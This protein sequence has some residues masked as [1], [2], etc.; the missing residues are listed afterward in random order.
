MVVLDIDPERVDMVN[1]RQSTVSDT[2]IETFLAQ[3]ELHL[4]ATLDK[5][6]AYKKANFVV[7][8]TPTNY[9]PQSNRFDTS[10]VDN[11]VNDVFKVKFGRINSHK[12]NCSSRSY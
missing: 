3:K 8:A 5:K 6:V 2:D 7:I 4:T 11:V 12:I 9:D 10:S 1:G